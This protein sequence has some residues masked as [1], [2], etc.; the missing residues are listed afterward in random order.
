MS[1]GEIEVNGSYQKAINEGLDRAYESI[2]GR[3]TS[4]DPATAKI[5]IFS[6]HHRGA[7]DGADDFRKCEK[8]YNAALGYYLE[9]G[10]TL[11]IL[12]DAEELWECRPGPV[13]KA[14]R[15]T[16]SLEAEFLKQQRYYRIYGNHDDHWSVPGTIDKHLNPNITKE[17]T[18]VLRG[19]VLLN[20][21]KK[22]K[23]ILLHGHQGTFDSDKL[24]KV[25]KF[26]VRHVWRNVQRI[27]NVRSTTPAEGADLK[28][29]HDKAMYNWALGKSN[30]GE[31]VILIAG[32]THLPVFASVNHIGRLEGDLKNCQTKLE[33]LRAQG[34]DVSDLA[35]EVA[36]KRAQLE[37]IKAKGEGSGLSMEKPCYFNTGCCSYGDGDVTAIEISKGEIRL[38]RWPDDLGNP[39]VKVLETETL[40]N[41]FT[42]I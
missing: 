14:Y 19:M 11:I 25:S 10:H 33:N 37:F 2:K 5:V 18:P 3:E 29:E 13:I 4:F 38:V 6:D 8:A 21:D 31:R 35:E 41:I 30:N 16:L 28:S 24:G 42:H 40:G 15:D 32:H 39:K 20:A 36:A 27:F 7:R 34:G 1:N 23:I 12:G 26:F 22:E 17:K 9:T